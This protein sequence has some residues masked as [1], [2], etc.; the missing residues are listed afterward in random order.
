[1]ATRRFTSRNKRAASQAGTKSRQ[2]SQRAK[3]STLIWGR[4]AVAAALANTHRKIYA[5]TLT[6]EASKAVDAML[7]T[8]ADDRRSTLPRPIIADRDKVT[9]MCPEGAIH[10]GVVLTASPLQGLELVTILKSLPTPSPCLLVVLDQVT[11]PRNAGSILRS[12][13]AFGVDFVIMADRYAP[14]E[15]GTLARAASGALD[16]QRRLKNFGTGQYAS[17]NCASIRSGRHRLA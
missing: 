10:Q 16:G 3:N 15:T 14:P 11:D 13:A 4:H 9:A 17:P 12:A 2:R 6:T 5:I 8:L 7:E 1:M